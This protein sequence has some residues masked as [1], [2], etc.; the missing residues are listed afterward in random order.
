LSAGARVSDVRFEL[1]GVPD[2]GALN[3]LFRA[4]WPAHEPHDFTSVLKRSLTYVFAYAGERLV[5][6]VN[7]AWDGGAH[8]FLLDPTVHPDLRRRGL[9]SELV[10]RAVEET[11]RRGIE[12]IAVDFEPQLAGFYQRCGFRPSHA[13]VIH[14]NP[15]GAPRSRG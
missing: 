2:D 13:G 11:R 7:V 4:A 12:W 15:P 10:R 1:G 5:G 3:A 9:G 6:Y 8:A 14:L